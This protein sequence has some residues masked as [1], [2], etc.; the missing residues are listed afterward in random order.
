MNCVVCQNVTSD[1]E[2]IGGCRGGG[3]P[4][5]IGWSGVEQQPTESEGGRF[6]DM[7]ES[8]LVHWNREEKPKA[9][10]WFQGR[11]HRVRVTRV[12]W[13]QARAKDDVRA[14]PDQA[15]PL[16]HC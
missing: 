8:S 3:R 15:G 12:A 4:Y 10:T 9:V 6:A 2:N 1:V 11:E 14:S 5:Y 13:T 7:G 16:H